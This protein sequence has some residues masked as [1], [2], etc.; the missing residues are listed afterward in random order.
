[1]DIFASSYH[2]GENI[3]DL[4]CQF[5]H[6]DNHRDRDTHDTT[7]ELNRQYQPHIQLL[8]HLP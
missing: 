3:S 7:N 4:A 6:D 8:I 5:K 1:M 2:G